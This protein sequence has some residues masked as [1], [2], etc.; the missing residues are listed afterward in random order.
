MEITTRECEKKY[1]ISENPHYL[2]PFKNLANEFR[3]NLKGRKR[4]CYLEA[5]HM[6]EFLEDY[7]TPHWNLHLESISERERSIG[8]INGGQK[9]AFAQFFKDIQKFFRL[10]FRLR[11]HR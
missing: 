8:I 6:K 5:K 2:K 10:I 9:F 11:F 4:R 7:V 3:R 1:K